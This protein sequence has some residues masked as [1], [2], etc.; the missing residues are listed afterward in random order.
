MMV[1]I[2]VLAMA[3]NMATVRGAG[4]ARA[5]GREM[6]ILPDMAIMVADTLAMVRV[7]NCFNFSLKKSGQKWIFI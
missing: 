2:T 3:K 1:F 6:A 5:N 7:F 4:M